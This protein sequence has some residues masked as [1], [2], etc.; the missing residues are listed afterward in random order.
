MVTHRG[1]GVGAG[2]E[3]GDECPS[4]AWPS[5]LVELVVLALLEAAVV[6]R[7]CGGGTVDA[8]WVGREVSEVLGSA[9]AVA[10]VPAPLTTPSF[11]PVAQ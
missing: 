4:A 5:L 7:L 10:P 11:V 2:G 1:E 8:R 3:E 9:P 6:A